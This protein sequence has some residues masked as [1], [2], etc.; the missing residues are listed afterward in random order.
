VHV[1]IVWRI[2]PI[3]L[4][5]PQRHGLGY[6]VLELNTRC[7]RH[8]IDNKFEVTPETGLTDHLMRK[9]HIIA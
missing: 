6:E 3:A 1:A 9:Q 8:N 5:D 2:C 7:C 4:L